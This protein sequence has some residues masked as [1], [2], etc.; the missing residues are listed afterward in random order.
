MTSLKAQQ[1]PEDFLD[2]CFKNTNISQSVGTGK[3]G[4]QVNLIHYAAEKGYVQVVKKLVDRKINVNTPT[5]NY[6]MRTSLHYASMYGHLE[7]ANL[8]LLNGANV[9]CEDNTKMTPLY[10]ASAN[11]HFEMV[12]LL[13]NYNA[14]INCQNKD[15]VTPLHSA[16]HYGHLEVAKLLF[17]RGANVNLQNLRKQTPLHI[18]VKYCKKEIVKNILDYGCDINIKDGYGKTAE[19]IAVSEGFHDIVELISQKRMESLSLNQNRVS[20][21][22]S[23][24]SNDCEICLEPKIGGTFAFIPCG[25][26]VACERC[27]RRIEGRSCPICRNV[28]NQ[29]HRIYL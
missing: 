2:W 5:P 16:A 7:V 6:R 22:S 13:L 26:T 11:G 8:L 24:D 9:N 21:V 25:H 4:D 23:E 20:Q 14:N 19:E 17:Q 1:I 27:C 10:Y 15:K 3:N 18:A 12:E 28:V 29:F